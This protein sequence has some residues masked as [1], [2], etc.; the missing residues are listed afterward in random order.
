MAKRKHTHILMIL[1][2]ILDIKSITESWFDVQ[3]NVNL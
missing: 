2:D 1:T 3:E